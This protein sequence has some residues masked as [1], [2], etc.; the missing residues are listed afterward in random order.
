MFNADLIKKCRICHTNKNISNF[1]KYSCNVKG[2][3]YSYR[4]N[5]CTDCINSESRERS[6]RTYT[7]IKNNEQSLEGE[8][9]VTISDFGGVYQVSNMG[10]VKRKNSRVLKPETTNRGYKRV[11]LSYNNSQ[12]KIS[13]HRLVATYFIKNPENKPEVNHINCI[14]HDNR[15]ENLEW[16]TR[17]ENINHYLLNNPKGKHTKNKKNVE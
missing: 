6:K 16:V 4:R 1:K 9:W 17:K 14:K 13:V 3:S 7:P 2:K 15:V 8:V 10:R 12:A 11:I 5:A